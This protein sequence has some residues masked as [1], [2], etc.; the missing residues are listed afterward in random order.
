MAPKPH[1]D[2]F[3]GHFKAISLFRFATIFPKFPNGARIQFSALFPIS[4]QGAEARN[5]RGWSSYV[6]ALYTPWHETNT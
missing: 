2:P 1:F 5:G 6:H 3:W 4:G